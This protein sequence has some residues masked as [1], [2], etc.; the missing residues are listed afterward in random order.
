MLYTEELFTAP[1]LEAP[2][3]IKP[4]AHSSNPAFFWSIV[5]QRER[6]T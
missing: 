2:E 1:G 3:V 5:Y 6:V 4:T